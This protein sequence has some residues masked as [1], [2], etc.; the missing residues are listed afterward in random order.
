M[1][2]CPFRQIATFN[3]VTQLNILL[4]LLKFRETMLFQKLT[5]DTKN[6]LKSGKSPYEVLMR[7][8]SDVMQALALTFGERNCMEYCIQ[9][10]D[11]M[12]N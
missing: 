1:Q 2:F 3:E 4:D 7:E 8:T 5:T 6:L 9:S 10:L 11:Q 12:S